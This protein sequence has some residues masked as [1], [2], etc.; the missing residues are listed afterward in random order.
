MC[1]NSDA[2]MR[3]RP[4][5]GAFCRRLFEQLPKRLFH[6]VQQWIRLGGPVP[7][8]TCDNRFTDLDD[9]FHG[10]VNCLFSGEVFA[11]TLHGLQNSIGRGP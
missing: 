1:P 10:P 8:G 5:H 6:G 3:C 9:G 7:S 11:E 4:V 2:R